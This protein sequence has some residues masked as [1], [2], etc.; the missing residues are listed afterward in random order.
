MI[1]LSKLLEYV[2]DTVESRD[3][4]D[5]KIPLSMGNF[6]W[7]SPDKKVY[8]YTALSL[9]QDIHDSLL[10]KI[11]G[12]DDEDMNAQVNRTQT[13]LTAKETMLSKG[14]I[15]YTIDKYGNSGFVVEYVKNEY[16]LMDFLESQY[17][18]LP[19]NMLA[20]KGGETRV[21]EVSAFIAAG[22]NGLSKNH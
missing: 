17:K 7:I 14:W 16:M 10:S 15:R 8:Y 13:N 21:G 12:P 11:M 18:R 20:D 9:G 5:P 1:K 3:I 4:T 6:G 22:F 2:S 19:K